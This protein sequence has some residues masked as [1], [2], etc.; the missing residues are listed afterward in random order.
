MAFFLSCRP[1]IAASSDSFIGRII[2][3]AG[4]SCA[5]HTAGLSYPMVSVESLVYADP[6]VFISMGGDAD[7]SDFF[8]VL[9]G[10]FNSLKAV[11]NRALFMIAPDTIPYYTPEDY[12]K[13]VEKISGIL[14]KAALSGLTP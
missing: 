10:D 5:Y 6:D 3:D 14:R 9:S 8:R 13:S 11:R 2:R 4:G 12:V 7:S 1:L